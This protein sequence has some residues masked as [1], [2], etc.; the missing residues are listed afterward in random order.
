MKR[1]SG[2]CITW[3]YSSDEGG[4]RV[5]A[6]GDAGIISGIYPA[7]CGLSVCCLKDN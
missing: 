2:V 6:S 7:F 3:W 5:L 4:G 1:I